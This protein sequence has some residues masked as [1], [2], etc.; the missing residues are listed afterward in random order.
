MRRTPAERYQRVKEVFFEAVDLPPAE[1]DGF[2]ERSCGDDPD[3]KTEVARLLA[4]EEEENAED[5]LEVPAVV[6][7]GLADEAAETG[8][9]SVLPAALEPPLEG[10]SRFRLVE[11]LGRGGMGEVWKAWDPRLSR[12]V[13]IKV[14]RRGTSGIAERFRREARAHARVQH[15]AVLEVFE[16]GRHGDELFIA[17]QLVDGPTLGEVRSSLTLD[18]RVEIV[19][20][21]AEGI[22][23]A[24]RR[25]LVHRDVKPSNVLVERS[26]DGTW[27]P[28][29][30]DFGVVADRQSPGLTGTG[31][32]I[33]TPDY[34]AP[35]RVF[36]SPKDVDHRSDVYS[37]GATLYELLSGRPPHGRADSPF[38]T[39]ERM[40]TGEPP[41]LRELAPE[42]PR[43]LEAI[44]HKALAR[45]PG[46][47]YPSARELADELARF[48]SGESVAARPSTWRETLVRKVRKHRAGWAIGTAAVL[49]VGGVL[50]WTAHARWSL[51]RDARQA[52]EIGHEIQE[53][54]NQLRVAILAP[55]HDVSA[56]E[57]HVRQRLEQIEERLAGARKG[58]RGPVDLA[59]GE[60]Y[61]TLNDP[62][63]ARVAL[64]R[65]W[66][67]GY[68]TAALS[69]SRGRALGRL[70][71]RAE[72]D[73]ARIAD[74][75]VRHERREEAREELLE[76]AL[77]QL[78]LARETAE[79]I[80]SLLPP[81]LAF[82]EKRF[83]EAI[84]A[85][86]AAAANVSWQYEAR[87]LEGDAWLALG[88][89]LRDRGDFDGAARAHDDAEEA[90]LAA[91]EV[92]RSDVLSHEGLCRLALSRLQLEE[93]RGGERE[94]WFTV[95][96][97]R[98][99]RAE[100]VDPERAVAPRALV[101]LWS[102]EATW[103]VAR[104]RDSSE[105]V[106]GAVA[107]ARRAVELRPAAT[108]VLVDLAA[109]HRSQARFLLESGRT[110]E[111]LGELDRTIANLRR[112]AGGD[113]PALAETLLGE[114]GAEKA[115]AV[116]RTGGD[117][118]PV[119]AE[120]IAALRRAL[121]RDDGTG[122]GVLAKIV[123]LALDNARDRIA[124]G[125]RPHADLDVA[126][127]ALEKARVRGEDRP[128]L[129]EARLELSRLRAESDP[130]PAEADPED[131]P[132]RGLA[133]RSNVV[134]TPEEDPR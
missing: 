31:E 29:V 123:G 86:R 104:G 13:A 46:D 106:D 98:C 10:W 32:I 132:K 21:V 43:D 131:R 5:F 65:A 6:G 20:R 19:R 58:T 114:V 57:K 71:D 64:D 35:E 9:R 102:L 47:R 122:G 93:L 69:W 129:R 1:R 4:R 92:A 37:L 100:S 82:H 116:G 117:P 53:L 99:L 126:A 79:E 124:R 119:R 107:A 111:A 83:E 105:L 95:G 120:A 22:H 103:R 72:Q 115:E 15:D 33:G 89:V 76:P 44:V 12:H 42:V 51:R 8:P 61:L 118:V 7:L 88:A 74:R 18:E 30:T 78:R 28:Y 56:D 59:L 40:K 41:R 3:L 133:T 36:G 55:A 67:S 45:A 34:M 101:G 50:V 110:E 23:E 16:T 62:D 73:A 11:V 68:R 113:D 97:D 60:A 80:P 54:E 48:L 24:H 25:G 49:L 109:V 77:G 112:V 87:R 127:E 66:D 26:E 96:E 108:D 70:A 121:E 27:R 128:A 84:A 39:F 85:A 94:P 38:E 90:F 130:G 81:L 91:L 52:Q 17:M 125:E 14:V 75:A 2:L 63:A 134:E